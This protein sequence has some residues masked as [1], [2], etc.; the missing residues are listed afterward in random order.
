MEFS[1]Y[2]QAFN[3]VCPKESNAECVR[4]LLSRVL[5]DPDS[6]PEKVNPRKMSTSVLGKYYNGTNGIRGPAPTWLEHLDSSALQ[7]DLEKLDSTTRWSLC[8]AFAEE[9]PNLRPSQV[10]AQ[11]SALL[12]NILREAAA[13]HPRQGTTRAP[14][15]VVP[16]AGEQGAAVF[17][18]PP[19][20]LLWEDRENYHLF[21]LDVRSIP[22]RGYW[23]FTIN[24]YHALSDPEF[25]D[26]ETCKTTACL[27][28]VTIRDLLRSPALL[29]TLRPEGNAALARLLAISPGDDGIHIDCELLAPYDRERLVDAPDDYA[30]AY[31]PGGF[32]HELN[33]PHWALK[34]IPL[35]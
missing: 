24:P 16:A 35:P 33:K 2:A 20:E 13:R 4:Y 9:L 5:K 26:P 8:S 19:P 32:F 29:V 6:L 23:R 34:H 1:A 10:P 27:D 15:S 17:A 11:L 3:S 12:E 30:L 14:S 7:K 21:V 22:G 31:R 18:A 25:N 28:P